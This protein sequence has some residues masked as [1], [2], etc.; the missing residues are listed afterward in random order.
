MNIRWAR[1]NETALTLLG[2]SIVTV[3]ALTALVVQQQHNH[4]QRAIQEQVFTGIAPAPDTAPRAGAPAPQTITPDHT[5]A[6]V[7]PVLPVPQAPQAVPQAPQ[8]VQVT[9]AA[10]VP[11]VNNPAPQAVVQ[12]QAVAQPEVVAQSPRKSL[13]FKSHPQRP[14]PPVLPARPP[15]PAKPGAPAPVVVP[16]TQPPDKAHTSDPDDDH[17]AT[18]PGKPFTQTTPTLTQTTPTLPPQ[19]SSA[20]TTP[21]SPTRAAPAPTKTYKPRPSWVPAS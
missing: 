3:G 9:P 2:I 6:P 7:P 10:P 15:A 16:A 1:S 4:N 17:T 20:S 14:A 21:A 13:P 18:K 12:S 19:T 8:A 5:I 11:I